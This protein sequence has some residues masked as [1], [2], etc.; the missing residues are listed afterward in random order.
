MKL[1]VYKRCQSNMPETP[2]LEG[3]FRHADGNIYFIGQNDTDFNSR[4]V[5]FRK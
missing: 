4:L 3:S 2:L 5:C 1:G